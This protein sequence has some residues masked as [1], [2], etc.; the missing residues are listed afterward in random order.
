MS[1][2][3]E[4]Q[5]LGKESK[6]AIVGEEVLVNFFA[7]ALP[8]LIGDGRLGKPRR[9]ALPITAFFETSRRRPISAALKPSDQSWRRAEIRS[10]VQLILR[11]LSKYL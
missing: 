6:R 9:C 5:N 7:D 4:I 11:N 3:L 8:L 10:S 2:K 1:D